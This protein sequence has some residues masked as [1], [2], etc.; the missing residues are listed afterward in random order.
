[1][2]NLILSLVCLLA[3][4]VVFGQSEIS[5]AQQLTD[6]LSE[7]YKLTKKQQADMLVVQERNLRNLSEI[8]DL[9]QTNPAKHIEKMRALKI[10]MDGSIE[11]ILNEEQRPLFHQDKAAFRKQKSILYSELKSKGASQNQI[12]FKI[13]ELEEAAILGKDF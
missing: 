8:E 5:P 1:M 7:K 10:G 3:T 9:K 6:K 2:K 11:K 4:V 12:E 13:A